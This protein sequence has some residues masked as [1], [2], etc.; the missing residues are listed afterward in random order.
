MFPENMI[1]TIKRGKSSK[2][3]VCSG[4]YDMMGQHGIEGEPRVES[5]ESEDVLAVIAEVLSEDSSVWVGED[6]S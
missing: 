2:I 6:G 5:P 1:V 4:E 3:F